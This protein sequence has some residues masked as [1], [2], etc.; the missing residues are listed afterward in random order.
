MLLACE[1]DGASEDQAR[2]QGLWVP[3]LGIGISYP[4]FLKYCRGDGHS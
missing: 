3:D 4:R 1:V 2:L